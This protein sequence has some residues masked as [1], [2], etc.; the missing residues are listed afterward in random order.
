MPDLD[1]FSIDTERLTLRRHRRE[2]L[3]E[4]FA[5]WSDSTVVRYIGGR[6]ASREEVWARLLRHVGHWELL[7][8][9]GWVVRE[10]ATGRFVGEVGL[11]DFQREM[12]P[13]LEFKEA[14]WVLAPWAHGQGFAAEAI[15]A[16]LRWAEDTFGPEPIVCIIHPENEASLR[17]AHRCGF[18]ERSPGT[19]KGEPTRILER[20]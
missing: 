18:R 7:G 15:H 5:M 3:E 4:S 10:K 19:Y 16:A 13:R 8:Y 17:V 20:R 11:A 1:R 12:S 6:P 2:D 14:G 9:G